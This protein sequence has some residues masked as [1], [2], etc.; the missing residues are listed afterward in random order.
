LSGSLGRSVRANTASDQESSGPAAAIIVTIATNKG[1]V[2][3]RQ[4]QEPSATVER[5]GSGQRTIYQHPAFGKIRAGRVEGLAALYG[6]DFEHQ[7]YIR[8]KI[9][10]S[11]LERSLSD[12]SYF[13]TNEGYIEVDLSEAQWA[14]F[15][16][17]LNVSQGVPCTVAYRDGKPIPGLPKPESRTQQFG[18]ELKERM[19][20]AAQ[21]LQEVE[22][23]VAAS[24]LSK[25][26]QAEM[27]A[28]LDHARMDIGVH[29]EFVVGRFD[30]HMEQTVEAAKTEVNAYLLG[31]IQR[32]GLE[33][34]G[35]KPALTLDYANGDRD[36]Q[37]APQTA[38]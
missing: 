19:A 27:R 22:D 8:I 29:A 2:M 26:K 34:L 9:G 4:I 33:A 20:R 3:P 24:G 1:K 23:L 21:R 30:E 11:R 13:T 28:S 16:S 38:P 7:R 6:S 17:S 12:D 32:A 36:E 37:P 5:D 10:P 14:T 31:S 15:V 35:A 25:A 18:G